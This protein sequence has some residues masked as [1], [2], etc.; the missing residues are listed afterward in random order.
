MAG[1]NVLGGTLRLCGAD[2]VAGFYRDGTCTSG[3]RDLAG[4]TVC[5]LMTAEFLEH[6]LRDGFDLVTPVPAKAFAGLKPG[7]AW[8]V[9][10]ERWRRAYEDGCPPPV[11]LEATHVRSLEEI[12]LS[13]LKEHR[14][15]APDDLSVLLGPAD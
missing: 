12:P 8:C 9:V 2:P 14:V 4:H 5:A 1:R 3:R 6:E 15:D 11:V 10:A 13:W 7:D